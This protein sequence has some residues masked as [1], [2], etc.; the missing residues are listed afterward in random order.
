MQKKKKIEMPDLGDIIIN[1]GFVK[2]ANY[3]SGGLGVV[4]NVNKNTGVVTVLGKY[5]SSAAWGSNN[6][7]SGILETSS[8]DEALSSFSGF[9]DTQVLKSY[10]GESGSFAFQKCLSVP[11]V[12]DVSQSGW[13]LPSVGEITYIAPVYNVVTSSMNKIK[14]LDRGGNGW[15]NHCLLTTQKSSSEY[16]C[17]RINEMIGGIPNGLAWNLKSSNYNAPVYPFNRIYL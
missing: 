15:G 6:Y 5:I 1:G 2:P 16:W 10:F 13:Y 8:Q 12:Q 3:S 11:P 7:I 9:E 17:W 4:V 14:G